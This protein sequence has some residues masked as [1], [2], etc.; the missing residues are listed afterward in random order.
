MKEA[1][2]VESSVEWVGKTE[3]LNKFSSSELFPLSEIETSR[4]R[5]R[6]RWPLRLGL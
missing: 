3:T 1:T 5:E 4:E 2:N 6:E